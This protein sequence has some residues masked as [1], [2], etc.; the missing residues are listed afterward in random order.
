MRIGML[1]YANV[2]VKNIAKANVTIA[3][4]CDFR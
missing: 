4:F 2:A 1:E 3:D